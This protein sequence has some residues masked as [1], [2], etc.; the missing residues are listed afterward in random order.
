[1]PKMTVEMTPDEVVTAVIE[2]A[3]KHHGMTV[4]AKAV[5]ISVEEAYRGYGTMEE[6]YHLARIS[7]TTK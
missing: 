5:S 1:M 4:D 7:F 2:W 3:D 6:K